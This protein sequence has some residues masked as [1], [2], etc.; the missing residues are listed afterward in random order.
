MRAW[1]LLAM[2][3]VWTGQEAQPGR[4]LCLLRPGNAPGNQ[5]NQSQ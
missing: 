2:S 1:A 4:P 3:A 5:I